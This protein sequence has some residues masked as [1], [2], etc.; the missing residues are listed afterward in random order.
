[1]TSYINSVTNLIAL[2]IYFG[3]NISPIT[4]ARNLGVILV[5]LDSI[6]VTCVATVY[7]LLVTF[8]TLICISINKIIHA[9][10]YIQKKCDKCDHLVATLCAKIFLQ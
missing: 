2:L 4:S 5:I 1:M 6:F 3:Q 8:V 10:L 7:V 9:G